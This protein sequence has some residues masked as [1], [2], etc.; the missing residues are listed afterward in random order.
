M[1]IL[2]MLYGLSEYAAMIKNKETEA[3]VCLL[4]IAWLE[5]SPYSSYILNNV[6]CCFY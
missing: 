6:H 3:L 2:L 1:I 4:L 5:N